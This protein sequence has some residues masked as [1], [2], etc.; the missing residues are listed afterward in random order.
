[1]VPTIITNEKT[2]LNGVFNILIIKDRKV[3]ILSHTP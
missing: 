2:D 1:M 3:Y